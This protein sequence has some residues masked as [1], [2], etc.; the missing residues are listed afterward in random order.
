MQE[1]ASLTQNL[2][3]HLEG[4]FMRNKLVL[5]SSVSLAVSAMPAWA[6]DAQ[7]AAEDDA[8]VI[9]VTAQRQSET[10]QDVPIAVSA[11]NAEALE[12]QQIENP[13]DLMLTLP[14]I[15]YTKG[16]FTG[17]SFTIRG[18][19]DL[20]VGASCDAATG[21]HIN[22]SPTPSTRLFETEFFDLERVEVL[23]GPQGT[24][25]G[26]NATSGVVNFITAKPKLGAFAV[27]AE[28]EY[29]NY[30]SMKFKGMV[31]LPI[32][33][34]LALRAAGYYL[35]RDG[36]TLN[37]YTGN[38][39]DNR[40]MYAVRG[41]LRWE[42]SPDTTVDLM[43]YYFK[44]DDQRLRIQKLMCHRDPTGVLG[45]LPDYRAFEYAN[46]NA[47]LTSTLPSVQLLRANGGAGLGAAFAPLGLVNLTGPDVLAGQTNPADFR[48]IRTAFDPTYKTSEQQYQ[49]TINH[50]FGTISV[51]LTGLYMKTNID[52][53]VDSGQSVP[54]RAIYATALN[55]LQTYATSGIP[56]IPGSA[57]FFAPA[58]AA[59]IPNGPTGVLCTSVPNAANTGVYGG[60]RICG[61][62]AITNDRSSIDGTRTYTLEALISSKF[63]GPFNFLL[64]GTYLNL[65]AS[66]I[67]YNVDSFGLDY[68]GAVLGALTALGRT[69]Q[70]A[71]TP[72]S[73]LGPTIF[74][75]FTPDY[76]LKSYGIFGEAYFE[77]SDKLKLTLGVRYNN[78][79][80]NLGARNQL[81]NFLVPY[82]T[83][84]VFAS[85]FAAG[86]DADPGGTPACPSTNPV[87]GAQSSTTAGAY[88]SV[89]GCEA[90]ARSS[91]GFSAVTG[92]AVLDYQ[93]TSDNLLY[94]SYSR[95]YKSGGINPP[96]FLAGTSTFKPEYVNAFE[97]GSK[98]KF[99][100][101]EL[102]LNA[103]AF[104]Y[105]YKG[106]QLSRIVNRTAVNDNVDADIYGMEIE[107]IV[108]PIRALTINMGA[109]YL[110]TKVTG[111]LFVQN[112][113][114]PAAGRDDVVI[115]K[116]LGAA[117]N[118]VVVPNTVGNGAGARQ[119]VT[120][121]NGGLGLPG[122]V[123]FPTGSGVTATGAHSLC[124]TLAATIANPSAGLRGLFG[125]GPAPAPL[126]FSVV[127]VGITQ[128]IKGKQLPQAPNFKWNVGVQ[129][130][131]PAG[132]I[133]ITPRADLI[134]VGDSY[135][136][137]FNG[138]I[139]RIKGY[140]Q[141]N[142][143]LQIDGPEKKWFVRG[144]VQNL[145]DSDAMTG[146]AVQDQSQGLY[147]GTF[148][149]EPRRYGIAAGIKF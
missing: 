90:F 23:R 60:S 138:P 14:N 26:R 148:T 64:G 31:N 102:T 82:G 96:L 45:C 104:Y 87:T 30:D 140:S 146:L 17:S 11:F 115:L 144:F 53:A 84:D 109:S 111:D 123:A 55:T 120:L 133:T 139:N 112:P 63:D 103:S 73:Y 49:A 86:Y 89:A 66:G 108:R 24:L 128:N 110:K 1:R 113:R 99:G 75:S 16:S 22:G 119:L 20:C 27:N 54:N 137:I 93:I 9:V 56:G 80:K 3:G 142:A 67:H 136:N 94:A 2:R 32:G 43:A 42:P 134:Y 40:D 97:I 107:A 135:G 33:D 6:Q 114:D 50:D 124:G 117:F 58:A 18:V 100:N 147:T 65:K 121:F 37:T 70:G 88:G 41:S 5:L 19:G 91:A 57:A 71:A 81:L 83:T 36:Y 39:V 8:D 7:D 143:Q 62:D 79:K 21:I 116:D 15:V 72:P 38:H 131:I 77:A 106:M 126:P 28:G 25:F 44:E 76:T 101:G 34:T 52:S 85:P 13:S 129:Y 132:D 10:L 130:E 141:I 105:Q 59:L 74:D 118:C 29:G 69:L 92:R 78:D 149:L 145:A 4:V 125:V 98:N 122:P 127:N 61:Q 95:G 48:T 68:A 46:A 12:R 51:E 47:T 35:K